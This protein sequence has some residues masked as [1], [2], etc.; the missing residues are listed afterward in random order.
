ME[1]LHPVKITNWSP[2]SNAYRNLMRARIDKIFS[3]AH[4]IES[5]TRY[6]GMSKEQKIPI[7]KKIDQIKSNAKQQWREIITT[8]NNF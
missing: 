6:N 3:E 5:D 1:H 7:Q 4:S 2:Q 8:S